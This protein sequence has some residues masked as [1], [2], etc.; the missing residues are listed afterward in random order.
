MTNSKKEKMYAKLFILR[1]AQ[2]HFLAFLS[3]R[4]PVNYSQET[5]PPQLASGLT[6]AGPPTI[7]SL[8]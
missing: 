4:R 1:E 8:L 2:S 6:V 5:E 7:V 3:G